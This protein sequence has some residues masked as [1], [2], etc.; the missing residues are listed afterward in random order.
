[1]AIPLYRQIKERLQTEIGQGKWA[2]GDCLPGEVALSR[3][4]QVSRF[5]VRQALLELTREGLLYRQAGKGTFVKSASSVQKFN[6]GKQLGVV[7]P[8]RTDAHTGRIL[9]GAEREAAANGYRVI[10]VN[11]QWVADEWSLLDE[12]YQEGV[13]GIIYYFGIS[14][15]AVENILRLREKAYPFVLIDHDLPEIPT[16]FVVADN[17]MGSYQAVKH[18]LA[19]GHTKIAMICCDKGMSSVEQRIKGYQLALESSGMSLAPELLLFKKDKEIS[20]GEIERFIREREMTAIFTADLI[21]IRVMRLAAK[22]GLSVPQRLSVVGFDNAPVSSFVLPS[23]TTVEQPCEEMGA[24][25][26]RILLNKIRGTGTL[27]QKVLQTKLIVRLSSAKR[28]ISE[29]GCR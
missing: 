16:D 28:V 18:L 3:Q 15:Q 24:Q 21:A 7:L 23:L 8:Y 10:F 17:F 2:V 1:M 25:A 20:D 5:T 13:A 19:L 22:L 14:S 12:L 9:K 6:Q 11:S 29:G 26:V 4:F 27:T